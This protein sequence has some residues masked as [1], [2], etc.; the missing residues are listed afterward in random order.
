MYGEQFAKNVKEIYIMGGNHQGVGNFTRCA[1]FNFYCDPEA[2]HIVMSKSKCPITILP[3]E[4][5]MDEKFFICIVS[6]TKVYVNIF[7]IYKFNA[8]MAS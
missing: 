4:P 1:E 8:E 7:Y 3:W 5:C 2:A 6:L